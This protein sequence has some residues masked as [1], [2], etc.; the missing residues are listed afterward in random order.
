MILFTEYFKGE[1]TS[2][3]SKADLEHDD[4]LVINGEETLC[5]LATKDPSQLPWKEL[6]VDYVIESTGFFTDSEKAKGHISCRCK[7]SYHFCSR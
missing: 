6:G 4:V 2:K 1:I 7:E 5:V 3:K